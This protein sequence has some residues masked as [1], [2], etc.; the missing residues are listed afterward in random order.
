MPRRT[1]EAIAR[2]LSDPADEGPEW[3]AFGLTNGIVPVHNNML[4]IFSE[5]K[6][7]R[8]DESGRGLFQSP[9]MVRENFKRCEN[10]QFG[11]LVDDRIDGSVE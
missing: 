2:A 6:R 7:E 1:A 10:F 9:K 11:V 5:L 8:R 4:A 3:Q